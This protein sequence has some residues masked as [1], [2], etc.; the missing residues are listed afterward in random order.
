[1]N[2]ENRPLVADELVSVEI[3]DFIRKITSH[4]KRNLWNIPHIIKVLSETSEHVTGW[5]HLDLDRLTY[6]QKS[7]RALVQ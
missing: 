4:F 1:M 2:A 3:Q 7:P 5:K 6:G